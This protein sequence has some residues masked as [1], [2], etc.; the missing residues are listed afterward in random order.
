[1]SAL[2]VSLRGRRAVTAVLAIAVLAGTI[3]ATAVSARKAA[4]APYVIGWVTGFTGSQA[5]NAASATQGLQAALA[6]VNKNN[7]AGRTIKVY[8]ADDAADPVT[9]G[10]VCNRLVNSNHVS[11]ILGF[12]STPSTAACNTYMTN[13][14][15]PYILA[16]TSTSGSLCLSNYFSLAN[17]GNQ[18]VNPL[19]SYLAKQGT[20]K[21]YIV[22]SDFSSGHVGT[23]AVQAQAQAHGIS[24]VGNSYEPLGTTDFSSDISKIASAQPD[25][26]IDILVGSDE[27]AFYKQFKTD[28]RSSGI[29]T[30]SFLMDDGIAASIGGTLLNGTI[31]STGYFKDNTSKGNQQFVKALDKKYGD[32]AEVSGAAA[33]AWDGVFVL[34]HALKTAKSTSGPDMITALSTSKTSGP[35]GDL[36]FKNRHYVSMTTYIVQ[37]QKDGTA[38]LVTKAQRITP[39]PANPTC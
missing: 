25:T 39:I 1:M 33:A 14:N 5:T 18:Q 11:A 19:M 10:N 38:K 21:V 28:P 4:P 6:Y 37:E 20:K 12:E 22:A 16:Q 13:N 8:Y 17:V 35:R 26:V 32:K 24:I 30:A 3:A 15:L 31:I 7:V 36:A 29:K 2:K 23:A 34:A 27:T 9:A